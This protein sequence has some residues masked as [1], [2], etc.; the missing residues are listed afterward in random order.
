[1][2]PSLETAVVKNLQIDPSKVNFPDVY[3]NYIILTY[4]YYITSL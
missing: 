4:I 1:M 3:I 2:D